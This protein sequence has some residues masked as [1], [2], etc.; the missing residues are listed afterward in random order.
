MTLFNAQP[1]L[2]GL[3][4]FQRRT[5]DHVFDQFYREGSRHFL[6]ADETGLGKSVVA[7]GLVA[8]SIEHLQHDDDI[9]QIDVV[10]V[11]SN[12]D[13]ARQNLKR[14][15]VTGHEQHQMASRL[16]MLALHGPSPDAERFTAM[17]KTVNL[18]SFTPG[19]TFE[20]GKQT[21]M[22]NERAVILALLKRIFNFDKR[23]F[24]AGA[25]LLMDQVTSVERFRSQSADWI[26]R[27]LERRGVDDSILGP[28]ARELRNTGL[29]VKLMEFLAAARASAE[30]VAGPS[31]EPAARGW[32]KGAEGDLPAHI[33]SQLRGFIGA[34]RTTL[35]NAS[36]SALE[37]DLVILDEFQKFPH[38]LRTDTPAG[39]LANALFSQPDARVLLLSATPYKPFALAEE[40]E[41][42]HERDLFETLTFL[43]N[44][45][46]N[47]DVE[48]IRVLL[49]K[50]R[51]AVQLG[52][53]DEETQHQLR[54]ELLKLMCR[55]ERP[56]PR[57]ASQHE[58]DP[59]TPGSLN[60]SHAANEHPSTR[61]L[62]TL[63]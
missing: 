40:S 25:K 35:A 9:D 30:P 31:P 50:Y 20:T 52:T 23:D 14:L 27:E 33:Q 34:L 60:P 13:L 6:V 1:V 59:S 45:N 47:A 10:Y 17:G 61:S 32:S 62:S 56:L 3:K 57:A 4:E 7:R 15:N 5:V 22:A 26:D 29:D 8:R 44:G 48:Q 46:R 55:N 37:P 16:T 2:D 41:D 18:I 12:A 24:H 36:L 54:R 43:A 39:E 28:F 38:L 58:N 51:S 21:G 19:T 53:H 49:R 42:A 63:R 11:C